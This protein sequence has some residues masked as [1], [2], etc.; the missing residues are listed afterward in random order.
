M[1]NNPENLELPFSLNCC[2]PDGDCTQC[3]SYDEEE[4]ICLDDAYAS[5][6]YSDDDISD[7]D[8]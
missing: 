3:L 5:K 1:K 2:R 7:S 6:G 8:F 4:N